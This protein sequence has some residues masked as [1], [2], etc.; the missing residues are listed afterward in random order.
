MLLQS[1]KTQKCYYATFRLPLVGYGL[2]LGQF[3]YSMPGHLAIRHPRVISVCGVQPFFH[4][5]MA[6]AHYIA[7]SSSGK[8]PRECGPALSEPSRAAF[9]VIMMLRVLPNAQLN[10]PSALLPP[11]ASEDKPS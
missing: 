10:V 1:L 3:S 11:C 6:Q 9:P 4:S 8:T 2:H 7:P 5:S